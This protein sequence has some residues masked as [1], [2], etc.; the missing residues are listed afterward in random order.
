MFIAKGSVVIRTNDAWGRGIIAF[1][2]S[3]GTL[4]AQLAIAFGAHCAAQ[5]CNIDKLT[6]VYE[7]SIEVV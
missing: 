2:S 4:V 1:C 5:T 3:C 6:M 7:D